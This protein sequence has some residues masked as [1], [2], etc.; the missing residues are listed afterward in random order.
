LD[1]K[2]AEIS[3]KNTWYEENGKSKLLEQIKELQDKMKEEEEEREKRIKKAEA[4]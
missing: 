4:A 1:K 2:I 3:A